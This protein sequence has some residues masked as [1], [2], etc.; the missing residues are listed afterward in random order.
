MIS[1]F[2]NKGNHSLKQILHE[3]A[4]G[5]DAWLASHAWG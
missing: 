1:M 3:Q 2:R 5:K 4:K